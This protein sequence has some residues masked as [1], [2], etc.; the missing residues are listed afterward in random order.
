MATNS[1]NKGTSGAQVKSA[2]GAKG[3]SYHRQVTELIAAGTAT[4][5]AFKIVAEKSGTTPGNISNTY[6]RLQR[7]SGASASATGKKRGRP[8][9][10]PNA[11]KVPADLAEVLD[12]L[13]K[14]RESL[15]GNINRAIAWFEGEESRV[16]SEREKAYQDTMAAIRQATSGL[17]AA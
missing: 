15:V 4:G 2:R 3:A 1:K 10:V 17:I 8:A 13:K 6:Y 7:A 5:E 16:N 14:D 9:G 12:S 11:V